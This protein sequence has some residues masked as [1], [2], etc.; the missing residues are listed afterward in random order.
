MRVLVRLVL[1]VVL[2]VCGCV[3]RALFVCLVCR[4]VLWCCGGGRVLL[5]LM[6]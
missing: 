4:G 5:G 6:G 2:V 3:F 1:L